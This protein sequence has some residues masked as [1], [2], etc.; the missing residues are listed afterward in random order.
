MTEKVIS[1]GTPLL[2]VSRVFC[3]IQTWDF[4]HLKRADTY[5]GIRHFKAL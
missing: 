1:N 2:K 4:C 5:Y 3:D